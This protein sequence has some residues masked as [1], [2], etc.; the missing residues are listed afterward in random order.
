MAC[1]VPPM[2]NR[3]MLRPSANASLRPPGKSSST[4]PTETCRDMA[5]TFSALGEESN[6]RMHCLRADVPLHEGG[7]LP[8]ARCRA[9]ASSSRR[10]QNRLDVLASLVVIEPTTA[11]HAEAALRD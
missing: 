8:P 2:L 1:T 7:A 4:E 11:L 10:R 9:Y 3:T 6:V 5:S